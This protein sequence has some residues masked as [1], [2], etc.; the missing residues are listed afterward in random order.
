MERSYGTI[1]SLECRHDSN[2]VVDRQKRY[3]QI[4]ECLTEFG[5]MS[6]REIASA[7]C[8]KGYTPTAERNYSSPRLNELCEKGIVEQKGK[9]RCNISGKT[10]TV[11]GLTDKE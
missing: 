8:L 2:E 3:R 11:Y 4:I 10:V 9:K 6:A 1:P 5:D 7:M